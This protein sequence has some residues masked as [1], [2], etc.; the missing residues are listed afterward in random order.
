M[1]GNNV[2]NERKNEE[3]EQV[4]EFHVDAKRSSFR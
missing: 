4:P 3:K 2:E 1:R